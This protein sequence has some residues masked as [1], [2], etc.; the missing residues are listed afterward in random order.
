MRRLI[1]PKEKLTE[2]IS[3]SLD[4]ADTLQEIEDIYR[5]F[6]PKRRPAH[7]LPGKKGWNLWLLLSMLKKISR[8]M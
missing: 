5:P 6:K 8:A 1:D 2:E 4:K 7:P 3:L